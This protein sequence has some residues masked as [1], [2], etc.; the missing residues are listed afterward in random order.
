MKKSC[1]V[2]IFA[3][4]IFL[5][6]GSGCSKRTDPELAREIHQ[7][8]QA[9]LSKVRIPD[10]ENG[11]II[12]MKGAKSLTELPEQLTTDDFDPGKKSDAVIL[13]AYLAKNEDALQTIDKGLSFEKFAYTTDFEKGASATIPEF[14]PLFRAQVVFLLKGDLAL[15]EGRTADALVEYL[16]VARLGTSL[17]HNELVITWNT[18]CAISDAALMRIGKSCNTSQLREEDLVLV[19]DR[20]RD[21]YGKRGQLVQPTDAEHYA[22]WIIPLAKA[23][24]G[25]TNF[26]SDY[27]SDHK[28]MKEF[29]KYYQRIYSE[30]LHKSLQEL[31]D[32]KPDIEFHLNGLH[33]KALFP[34][35]MKTAV[36]KA[37]WHGTVTVAGVHMFRVKNGKL[38]VD[39]SE[40]K[41]IV[42]QDLRVDPFSG[43][44]LV[45]R[46]DGDDFYLY[47]IGSDM[48]DD[49][50][51]GSPPVYG[52]KHAYELEALKDIVFHKP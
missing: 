20:L 3:T 35:L 25:E 6:S 16:S 24:A 43:K 12:V 39:L 41:S 19:I 28:S 10:S 2:L 46:I 45:Y 49:A 4:V 14:K 37:L 31:G 30:K 48:L 42:P 23:A 26:K 21:L 13:R 33:P 17:S 51:R 44:H 15:S 34:A 5:V 36:L 38:P 29:Q 50:G 18:S 47:S 8:V 9:W 52:Q 40:L 11:A 22:F 27:R 32:D 1:L 7:N